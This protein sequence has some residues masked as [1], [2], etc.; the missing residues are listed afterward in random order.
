VFCAGVAAGPDGGLVTAGGRV[1]AVT[2][3]GAD[4][5]QARSRAYEA[6]GHV[7]WPGLH[8]RNDIAAAAVAD[9]DATGPR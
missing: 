5:A 4:L 7:S 1:L 8:H 9:L 2:G 6:V 3:Q